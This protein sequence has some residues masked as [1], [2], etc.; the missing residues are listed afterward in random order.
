MTDTNHRPL[1]EGG[2]GGLHG[3]VELVSGTVFAESHVLDGYVKRKHG[4]IE[5]KPSTNTARLVLMPH[6]D[7]GVVRTKKKHSGG[8]ETCQVDSSVGVSFDE[9]GLRRYT[10]QDSS[11]DTID[12]YSIVMCF[13]E[14]SVPWKKS[15]L[16]LC[17]EDRGQ[18]VAWKEVL[19]RFCMPEVVS[20]HVSREE[21]DAENL[22]NTFLH[23]NGISIYTEAREHNLDGNAAVMSSV[24]IRSTPRA[25]LKSLLSGGYQSSKV[26]GTMAF[27]DSVEVLK[28]IDTFTSIVKIKWGLSNMMGGFFFSPRESVLQRTW[29]KD[30][31][32]TYVIVYQAVPE[33][34]LYG[35][36]ETH[37]VRANVIAAGFTIAPL[38]NEYIHHEEQ[39]SQ[40]S[41]VTLVV[42][43]DAGGWLTNNGI[44]SRLFPFL[45]AYVRMKV[46]E[47]LL[48]SL[49]LLRD[50]LEQSRF[51]V[52]PSMLSHDEKEDMLEEETH[53]HISKTWIDY[54]E[55][56]ASM[57]Q[58]RQETIHRTSLSV[59]GK[60]GC[61]E[62]RF[63]SYPG[64]NFLKIRG[65]TYLQDK[66]KV[67]AR[68]PVFELY[69][70][71]LIDSDQVLFHVGANLPSVQ[72]CDAPYA[73]VLNLVF[74]NNP[75]QSL[76]TVWTC[77][78][79]PTE[80]SIDTL[81]ANWPEEDV[82]G[83]LRAFFKNFREWVQ[84]D[85]AVDDER[86]NKKFKLIPRVAKGSWVV[87]QSVGTT[88]VLLGQKLSSK[89]FR[90]RTAK[91]CS[92]FEMDVDITSNTV[93]NNVTKLVVNSITSLVVDLS[94]LIE[95]QAPDELPERLI[96]S[97]RYT[98][99]DLKTA[100]SWDKEKKTII[101]RP[102]P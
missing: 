21:Q 47:P 84:G 68:S 93:A 89:Y 61:C 35:A 25:C 81:L 3:F 54:S 56:S 65:K 34:D 7:A 52:M 24:V 100:A 33:D 26:G 74:P 17:F 63:W 66:I 87:R 67:Q 42:K 10:L 102:S 86:R 15:V 55:S 9:H 49:I 5:H 12:M 29:R 48:M 2:G 57:K 28:R 92:Y 73:F 36:S 60:Q 79:D 80:E 69:S 40:E 51:T 72:F 45:F 39:L 27:A 20:R 75:L 1:G 91:G 64:F 16:R 90:G 8:G 46:M 53:E 99:L 43:A 96:G 101:P 58:R 38:R 88:P 85:D 95:G 71:D 23:I 31:D 4:R 70:S 41:L 37:G 62:K 19:A 18:A 50:R 59:F 77:P 97:V 6:T 13:S 14:D 78:V 32:G 82:D 30:D 98:H 11:K 83:S 94:P 44:F 76:V 22:W